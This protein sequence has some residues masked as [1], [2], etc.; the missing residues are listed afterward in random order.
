MRMTPTIRKEK[1]VL[2]HCGFGYVRLSYRGIMALNLPLMKAGI[3]ERR[4]A[5]LQSTA[6]KKGKNNVAPMAKK[7]KGVHID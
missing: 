7:G 1:E 2:D 6:L 5:L 3:P 4:D